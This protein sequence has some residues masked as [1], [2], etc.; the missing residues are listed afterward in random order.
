MPDNREMIEKSREAH[1]NTKF[2][3]FL[4]FK[5]LNKHVEY[6]LG[7]K[8]LLLRFECDN[9]DSASYA[10]YQVIKGVL[11]KCEMKNDKVVYVRG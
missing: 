1:K 8:T 3:F 5:R 2:K 11:H 6:S 10:L 7:E 4:E 9:Q